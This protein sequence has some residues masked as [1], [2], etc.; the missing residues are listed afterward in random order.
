MMQWVG[1]SAPDMYWCTDCRTIRMGQGVHVRERADGF[2]GGDWR[3][4]ECS[5]C[6]RHEV[7]LKMFDRPALLT[8]AEIE[9]VWAE[10]ILADQ[11]RQ[12]LAAMNADLAAMNADLTAY[13]QRVKETVIKALR[14]KTP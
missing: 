4:R 2:V 9:A 13:E 14:E 11:F 5:N 6:V 12:R 8:E 1:S 7:V 3:T 10:V